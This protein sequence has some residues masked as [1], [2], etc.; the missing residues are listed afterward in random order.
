MLVC[1]IQTSTRFSTYT[2]FFVQHQGGAGC[3]KTNG[4]LMFLQAA[5][6]QHG[7]RMTDAIHSE[8]GDGKS[9]LDAAFGCLMDQIQSKLQVIAC[10][11]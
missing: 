10:T 3:Y 6:I 9:C 11:E 1:C 2:I 4:L 8:S 5:A 7:M